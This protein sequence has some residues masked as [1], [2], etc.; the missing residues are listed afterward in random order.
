MRTHHLTGDH[1]NG[2]YP[3]FCNR[4]SKTRFKMANDKSQIAPTQG[5][6]QLIVK[7]SATNRTLSIQYSPKI[8]KPVFDICDPDGRI[9]QT[10]VVESEDHTVVLVEQ[11]K[12]GSR[13][14]LWVVDCDLIVKSQFL[15]S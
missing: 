10:C 4:Q 8:D 15:F 6:Q 13:Y 1:P 5:V 7:V 9:V 3:S 2:S 12:L 11:V 14:C